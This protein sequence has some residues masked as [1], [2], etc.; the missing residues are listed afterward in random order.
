M[1]DMKPW[2]FSLSGLMVTMSSAALWMWAIVTVPVEN[3][4]SGQIFRLAMFL[5]LC[6]FTLTFHRLFRSAQLTW[7]WAAFMAGIIVVMSILY[8]AFDNQDWSIIRPWR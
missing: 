8:L 2:Q 7:P 1:D 5:V 3:S 6:S 4:L